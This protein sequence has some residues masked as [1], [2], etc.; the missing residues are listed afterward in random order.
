M[1]SPT[2]T[3][4]PK[5][6]TS[7]SSQLTV[8][9]PQRPAS[10]GAQPTQTLVKP[11]APRP[12][13]VWDDLGS[14]S[15]PS[16]N[17]SLP[18]QYLV[19]PA[20]TQPA[21]QPSTTFS[22]TNPYANLA[23]TPGVQPQLSPFSQHH[24]LQPQQNPTMSAQATGFGSG[25][26]PSFGTTPGFHSIP[27]SQSAN[28]L[29]PQLQQFNTGAT[30]GAGMNG[31]Q[32]PF[33]APAFSNQTFFSQQSQNFPAQQ[34]QQPGGGMLS[35]TF[36]GQAQGF[37]QLTPNATGNPFY[38]MQQQQHQQAQP[39]GYTQQQQPFGTP[40]SPANPFTQMMQPGNPFPTAQTPGWQ[41]GGF[42]TQQQHWG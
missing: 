36:P 10:T 31:I 39:T 19:N 18:L 40:M 25:L 37:Q 38:A 17:A 11:A 15:T 14:L 4:A 6:T 20:P 27:Q 42:P 21:I 24:S 23:A 29:N 5:P 33:S 28:P 9:L 8:G 41:S 16:T 12:A 35:A 1:P 26:Q 3:P 13:S 30:L 32:Q 2:S 22:P 34:F 7:S